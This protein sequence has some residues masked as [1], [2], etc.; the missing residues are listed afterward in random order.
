MCNAVIIYATFSVW[1]VEYENGRRKTEQDSEREEQD[2]FLLGVRG[3]LETSGIL[4]Q[5]NNAKQK[6]TNFV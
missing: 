1:R 3:A 2:R 6:K 4:L 5:F